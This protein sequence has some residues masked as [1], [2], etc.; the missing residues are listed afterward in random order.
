[1]KENFKEPVFREVSIDP[2]VSTGNLIK[3]SN[4]HVTGKTKIS[5]EEDGRDSVKVI[6][7]KDQ[8]DTIK[9]IKFVCSCGQTKTIVLDYSE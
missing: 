6:L 4:T 3:A 8:A 5:V 2:G 7:K 9:E 1:M